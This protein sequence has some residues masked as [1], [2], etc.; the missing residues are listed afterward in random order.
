MKVLSYSNKIGTLEVSD[1]MEIE[2]GLK[3]LFVEAGNGNA[4]DAAEMARVSTIAQSF[5]KAVEITTDTNLETLMPRFNNS[6]IPEGTMDFASYI[7]YVNEHVVPHS[8]HTSSPR[9]IGHMTSAL[10]KFVS[11][12][13][14]LTT[15]MNQ[16]L[17]KVETSKAMTLY[18][19]QALAMMHRLVYDFSDAFYAEHV[20]R[21]DSTLG[22]VVSGGTLANITALWCARNSSLG[23][24]DGF[25]GIEKEGL[26]AGLRF[27][28]YEKSVIIGSRLMHYSF[29]KAADLLGIGVESLIEV[30]V[31]RNNRI[32]LAALRQAVKNCK[33]R[34]QHICAIV[35]VA[36]ATDCGS[37]D[38]LLQAAE[39]AREAQV[40]FHVDAAWGGPLLFSKQHRHKLAGIELAD[41]VTI[42]GH[43]QLYLPMGMGMLMLRNPL[44]ARSIE[45]HARYIIRPNSFDLGKRAMEGSRPNTSL[46]Y[47]AALNVIGRRGYEFLIDEGIR[48]ARYMAAAVRA[49]PEFELLVEPEINILNYRFV[50]VHLRERAAL[51]QLTE[52]DDLLIDS[53]NKRLQKTQRQAGH[54][55]VS[56]TTLNIMRRGEDRPVTALRAVLAN[57]LT[58]ESDIDAVLK[59]QIEIANHLSIISSQ[60]A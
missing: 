15:A 8:I 43:K 42:D 52:S 4:G 5:V 27:Y 36:G 10:P 47:H 22:I 41:S 3:R 56:R 54:S 20:Q 6:E 16:N 59:D 25:A 46:L 60:P 11:S 1:P 32:D 33:T 49:L 44:S 30:P 13:E 14:M 21:G 38:S 9:F 24:R 58:T 31:D 50:P 40:H 35:G 57:P 29:K 55:F 39:I 2:H 23:P 26:V 37:I 53:L 34:N 17:V 7:E 28:G 51:E 19:R 12:L 18:E 45:K 48:K